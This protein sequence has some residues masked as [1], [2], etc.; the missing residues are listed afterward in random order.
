[1]LL[2][3]NGTLLPL[4]KRSVS[5]APAQGP[6]RGAGA[7]PTHERSMGSESGKGDPLTFDT[8]GEIL[9]FIERIAVLLAL[10]R[11]FL[12]IHPS[13]LI[14]ISSD[15]NASRIRTIER[16]HHETQSGCQEFQQI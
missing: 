9:I 16:G 14:R 13:F 8:E 12:R 6:L 15:I 1:M 11:T 10:I 4:G 7:A 3:P 5:N 2:M